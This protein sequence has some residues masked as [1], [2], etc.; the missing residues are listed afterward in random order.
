LEVHDPG[1]AQG[2]KARGVFLVLDVS[3][4]TLSIHAPGTYHHPGNT[5]SGDRPYQLGTRS[6][7]VGC[8]AEIEAL[9]ESHVMTGVMKL[10]F[11]VDK[12]DV[13]YLHGCL[14]TKEGLPAIEQPFFRS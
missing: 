1:I 6:V 5:E 2:T 14:Q 13:H 8:N 7:T 4:K 12:I 11:E 9:T 10:V 3:F